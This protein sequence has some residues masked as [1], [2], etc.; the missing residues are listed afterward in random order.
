MKTFITLIKSTCYFMIVTFIMF[1][2]RGVGREYNEVLKDRKNNE[3]PVPVYKAVVYSGDSLKNIAYPLGGITTGNVLMGGRGNIL[4]WEIFGRADQDELPP[5]MTFFALH[6]ENANGLQYNRILEGVLPDDQ[7][8]PFGVPR[9]QLTGIPRFSKCQFS[10]DFPFARTKLSDPDIPVE[11][12]LT[13]WS[14]FI[15]LETK[16]SSLPAVRFDWELTNTGTDSLQIHLAFNFANPFSDYDFEEQFRRGE[17][18][19]VKSSRY[20]GIMFSCQEPE[21][22]EFMVVTPDNQPVITGRWYRGRWW[23]NSELFWK[24]FSNKGYVEPSEDSYSFT[25]RS[26]T[27]VSTISVPVTLGPGEK[28]TIS[29]NVF[30]RIPMRKAERSMALGSGQTPGQEYQNWYTVP[31]A[32]VAQIANEY[33]SEFDKLRQK[34]KLFRDILFASTV[35]IYVRDAL[36]SNLYALRSN[37]LMRNEMGKVH[38]FEGLGNDFGCCPGNCAHVWNYAQALAFLFPDLERDM[39]ETNFL[40]DTHEDGAMSFRT[41]FPPGP[42]WMRAVAADGQMGTIIRAYREWIYTGDDEWLKEIWPGIKKALEFAWKGS[43]RGQIPWDPNQEGVIRGNQHNTYDINFFGPNMLTGSLYLGALK[44]AS[45]MALTMGENDKSEEYLKLYNSG[46]V[47]YEEQLWN[48]EYYV[49]KVEVPEGVRLPESYKLKNEEGPGELKPKYQYENGCLSDQL[50]G[51]FLCD[52]T[53]LGSLVD[54]TH[55]NR[56]LLS[57]YRYNFVRDFAEFENVQRVYALNKESGLVLCSWP[58]GNKPAVPFVYS[59]EVWTG[60]EY[61]VAASLIY[62]GMVDE[63]LELVKATR[64]RYRGYNRN[65]FAEIESGRYYARSLSNWAL[66]TALSGYSYNGSEGLMTF[67]PALNKDKFYTFWSTGSAWGSFEINKKAVYLTVLHGK[68]DLSEFSFIH[69]SERINE[70]SVSGAVFESEGEFHTL[71]FKDELHLKETESLMIG[72][73]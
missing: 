4:E 72:M 30:W 53:G 67:K 71:L 16:L 29:F 65:P 62:R 31:Y 34:T 20:N 33:F 40:H 24:E 18:V 39:R 57:V 58:G 43:D 50:L 12:E 63:G 68:L 61:Q 17:V 5:Y 49:Q 70:S 14:P 27:D 32:D 48:G 25:G 15:P 9:Q 69:F 56:A 36:A 44:A 37:L 19:C 26:G 59:D 35:P 54:S 3:R 21:K 51:Q 64:E 7:P 52:L 8:N 13:G 41:V 2:C 11:A 23:D 60:V 6:A 42:Y 73:N 22:A 28:D 10:S 46:R 45:E 38:A 55:I 66:I 47:K 1:S